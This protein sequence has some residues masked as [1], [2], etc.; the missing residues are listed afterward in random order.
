MSAPI[1]RKT[2]KM[3]DQRRTSTTNAHIPTFRSFAAPNGA[4]RLTDRGYCGRGSRWELVGSTWSGRLRH[5]RKEA[6]DHRVGG[7]FGNALDVV[8]GKAGGHLRDGGGIAGQERPLDQDR[9]ALL[10]WI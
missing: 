1:P 4:A 7:G 8:S 5:R 2:P 9:L 10:T 6:S 3:T